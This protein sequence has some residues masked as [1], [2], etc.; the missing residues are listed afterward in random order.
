MDKN[1]FTF[2]EPQENMPG[3][4]QLCIETWKKFL[5][6]YK[7]NILNYRIISD[8]LD[9]DTYD[10]DKLKQFSLPK[11][12]DAIRCA[13]LNKFGGIWLDADTIILSDK[14]RELVDFI[15]SNYDFSMLVENNEMQ[16]SPH[17]CLIISKLPNCRKSTFF[18][19]W[20]EQ[21]RERI[22]FL[23]KQNYN[24]LL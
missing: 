11:Q 13:L 21:A 8:Y 7:I 17:I 12:A 5:P 1:I 3:Y 14:F 6:D 16:Y 10:F 20:E 2:W 22:K 18:N 15:C 23:K 9:K 4:L 19:Q 24:V